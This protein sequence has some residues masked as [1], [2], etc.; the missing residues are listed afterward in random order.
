MFNIK[1]TLF[2]AAYVLL[3][4]RL[5][6]GFLKGVY[7]PTLIQYE[8]VKK[9][10]IKTFIDVG[11]YRG[12]DSK[13]MNYLLPNARIYA[14]EPDQE[15]YKFI[16][17]N[18]KI[19]NFKCFNVALSDRIGISKFYAHPLSFLSSQLKT[20]PQSKELLFFNKETNEYLVKT[21]TMDYFF[22][23]IDMEGKVLLKIDT[24]GTEG[25][26]L[27]GCTKTLK[28]IDIVHIETPFKKIYKNQTSFDD[29]YNLLISNGFEYVGEAKESQFYP[30]FTTPVSCNSLFVK[31]NI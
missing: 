3:N 19:K 26:V 17:K 15:N 16:R 5:I 2:F 29:I 12:E 22:K 11:A 20:E 8:W 31:R 24:Q 21:T 1:N 9:Q 28:K 14:F 4:P 6:K 10:D 30:L 13:V 23:N 27:K 25:K 7:V 18:L